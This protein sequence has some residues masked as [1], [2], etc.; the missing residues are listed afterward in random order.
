V[1]TKSFRKACTEEYT[2]TIPC[3]NWQF[4]WSLSLT[5][6]QRNVIYRFLTKNIPT[7]R[8]LHHFRITDS[9]LCP[10]CNQ[11]K[12]SAY[13]LF[14]CP[15]KVSVWQAI[16]FEF[17]WPTVSIGDVIRACSSLDFTEIQ[18]VSKKY[19]TAQMAILVTL[20]NIWRAQVKLIFH[21]APFRWLDVVQQTKDEIKQVHEGNEIHKQL[22]IVFA[23]LL[24]N[25][26]LIIYVLTEFILYLP[27]N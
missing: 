26:I 23:H 4:F 20:A 22:Q 3:S 19:I 8:L 9:P 18:Y 16:I 1:S 24:H 25:L 21:S 27:L 15:S 10:I 12:N 7:K 13:L 11:E 2:S 17:L 14:L 6:V 5:L